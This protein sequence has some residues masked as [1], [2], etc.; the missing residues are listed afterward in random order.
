MEGKV[1]FGNLL[2]LGVQLFFSVE[3]AYLKKDVAVG[4][5]G[6][7]F[8]QYRVLTLGDVPRNLRRRKQQCDLVYHGRERYRV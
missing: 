7:H 4:V 5:S 3:K 1:D 6:D 2:K 8:A